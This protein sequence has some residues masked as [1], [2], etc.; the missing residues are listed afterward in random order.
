MTRR[1]A[2]IGGG[3]T[4]LS[5]AHRLAAD[6]EVVLFEAGDRLGGQVHTRSLGGTAVDVGADAFLA[7]QPEA[8]EL[9]RELGLGADLVEPST[10]QVWLW[11]RGRR[12][13]L[14]DGAIFGA[15]TALA[16]LVRSRVLTP[17]SLARAALEPLLP[18]RA[19]TTDRSVTDLVAP[20]FGHGVVE[21]LVEPLL[22]GV[23]AGDPGRLSAQAA[24]PP[25][26]AAA[27]RGRSLTRG[28]LANRREAPPAHGPVFRTVT[29][30]LTRFVEALAT[31]LGERVR[32]GAP[33]EVIRADGARWRVESPD[34]AAEGAFDA[35]VVA[36]PAPAAAR[37]LADAAPDTAAGLASI[38]TASVGVVSLAYPWQAAANA[39]DGSGVLVPRREG[40]LV[41]AVTVSSRKWPHL[42]DA[43]RFLVRASVGRID[44][45]AWL[46]LDDAALVDRV[47]AEVRE[48]VGL[49][50]TA[51]ESLVTR[52]LDALP[53]YEV[54][55]VERTAA[56][57]AAAP[58]G[59]F[60]GGSAF[61]GVGLA[62]RVRDARHLAAAVH[63]HLTT[64][65]APGQ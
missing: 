44:D 15:P 3:V 32:T 21:G 63:R 18:A 26:W 41:K 62:G 14:P 16:P 40:R 7:R 64:D 12:R 65:G 28:L 36:L 27:V 38:A 52:W 17:A 24:T 43:G 54:G 53:Q 49:H 39:M 5:T 57:R 2:V 23:Y 10:G 31:Q 58:A 6:A 56:I 11:A 47:D 9:A 48:L 59:I 22:G 46:E 51:E 1:V 34:P 35:V 19:V 42:A 55:H 30:G 61:D 13:P 25:L 60:I 4:G 33:V 29:G 37:L 8:D 20:R 45:T 50:A